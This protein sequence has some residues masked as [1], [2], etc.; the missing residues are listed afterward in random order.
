MI[1]LLVNE[2]KVSQET[3]GQIFKRQEEILKPMRE[4][5]KE[6]EN[7]LSSEHIQ[8]KVLRLTSEHLSSVDHFQ[9]NFQAKIFHLIKV[10]KIKK[11]N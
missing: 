7:M 4:Y 5:L 9:R 11:K 2:R 10:L 8:N 3:S 6:K 1:D